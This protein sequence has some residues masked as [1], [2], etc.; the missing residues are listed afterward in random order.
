MYCKFFIFFVMYFIGLNAEQFFFPQVPCCSNID[1]PVKMSDN[2]VKPTNM[3][4][5]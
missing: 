2:S 1:I 3:E 5:S 4:A